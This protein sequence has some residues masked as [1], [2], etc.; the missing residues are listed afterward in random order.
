MKGY[1]YTRAQK[2][3]GEAIEYEMFREVAEK[4]NIE[5][6][7]IAFRECLLNEDGLF[8]NGSPVV[9]ADFVIYRFDDG[10]IGN[11]LISRCNL[12]VNDRKAVNL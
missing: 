11:E 6:D 7:R 2:E 9:P 12:C 3:D 10:Q 5:F 1:L 8:C 4:L